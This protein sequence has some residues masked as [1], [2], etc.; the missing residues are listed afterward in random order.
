MQGTATQAMPVCIVEERHA[1]DARPPPR[2][3]GC[4]SQARNLLVRGFHYSS[5][6]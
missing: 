6:H 2:P 1:A 3:M 5:F 4:G